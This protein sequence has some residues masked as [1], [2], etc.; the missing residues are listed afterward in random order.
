MERT[1][2]L[3]ELEPE[4]PTQRPRRRAAGLSAAGLGALVLLAAARSGHIRGLR[5]PPAA[6]VLVAVDH[7]PAP[8]ELSYS[9]G[10]VAPRWGD[11]DDE[12]DGG[13][14]GH[15]IQR[16]GDGGDGPP[17]RVYLTIPMSAFL[18]F[19]HVV[20]W[21][22]KQPN[23]TDHPQRMAATPEGTTRLLRYLPASLQVSFRSDLIAGDMGEAAAGGYVAFDM[24]KSDATDGGCGAYETFAS[25]QVV[26]SLAGQLH[27]ISPTPSEWSHTAAH[28]CGFKNYDE[29]T[30]L[31]TTDQNATEE[32]FV[33][34]WD[35]R[36]DTYEQIG[37]ENTRWG[38]H[39]IQWAADGS[40]RFW[41]GQHTACGTDMNISLVDA[42][43]G[44]TSAH[45]QAGDECTD[46][47]HAQLLEDDTV[48]LVSEHGDDCFVKYN[49]SGRD[50]LGRTQ[51]YRIGGAK[52]TWPIVDFDTSVE[53]PPGSVV[54]KG[55]HNAE[56]MGE[57][58][59]WMCST[60]WPSR[61]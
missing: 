10:H 43:T 51:I 16:K 18:E 58:E 35:W 23:I 31:V 9:Y 7:A 40:D 37:G 48:A 22:S 29:A 61:G 19:P 50:A 39:D 14:G 27:A 38:T 53:Y 28:V 45:V 33:Y 52:G 55:Q 11:G 15:G 24:Y 26:V 6:A 4:W 20:A 30:M 59:V 34:K 25:W 8:G 41:I 1:K 12:G 3:G 44:A 60:T 42:A 57:D 54:W 47:N 46:V 17:P 36:A 32:G 56:Y 13:D 5:A 2:L 49:V 21:L